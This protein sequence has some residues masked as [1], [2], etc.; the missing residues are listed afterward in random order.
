MRGNI[1]VE[2]GSAQRGK[3]G[4][5]RLR[6]GQHDEIGVARKRLAR[7]H[8]N[9]IDVGLSIERIEIVEIRDM[10]QDGNDDPNPRVR[11]WRSAPFECERILGGQQARIGEMRHQTQRLPSGRLRDARHAL[12]E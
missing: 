12:G 4:D 7:P 10:R 8:V 6:A 5:G 9:E 11:L 1:D 3:I 2:S